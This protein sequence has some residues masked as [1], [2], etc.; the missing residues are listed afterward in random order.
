MNLLL[1]IGAGCSSTE[2]V[3]GEAPDSIPKSDPIRSEAFRAFPECEIPEYFRETISKRLSC[4]FVDTPFADAIT[5]LH[6]ALGCCLVIDPEVWDRSEIQI[7]LKSDGLLVASVLDELLAQ[8]NL[9]YTW[10]NDGIFITTNERFDNGVKVF[11]ARTSYFNKTL[12]AVLKGVLASRVS[13]DFV[14]TPLDSAISAISKQVDF[15]IILDATILKGD[16]TPVTAID[17]DEEIR[18]TLD[19]LTFLAGLDYTI[20]GRHCIISSVEKI[21]KLRTTR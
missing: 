21:Q 10:W 2:I 17:R 7:T 5:L 15:E 19:R 9:I 18:S 11:Q 13:Y 14:D 20:C 16:D 3:D 8:V 4:D 1:F 12:D 6:N